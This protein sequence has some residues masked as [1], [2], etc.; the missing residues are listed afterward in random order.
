MSSTDID[1]E[2]RP[3]PSSH[4]FI[5]LLSSDALLHLLDVQ[6]DSRLELQVFLL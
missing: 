4:Q 6:F 1:A 2:T 3:D 5:R